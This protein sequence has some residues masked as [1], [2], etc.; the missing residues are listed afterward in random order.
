MKNNKITLFSTGMGHF[1]RYY[2]LR[3]G[4][5]KKIS[6]P[7][8]K[9]HIGDVATSINAFGKVKYAVPPSFAPNNVSETFLQ[10]DPKNSLNSLLTSLSGSEVSL[11]YQGNEAT[12]RLLG[13]SLTPGSD[14]E[15]VKQCMSVMDDQNNIKHL[16]LSYISSVKFTNEAVQAEINKALNNNFQKIK[17]EST[18]LDLTLENL[19]K[20]E[21][22]E[23]SITY[24]VPVAAWKM[25]YSIRQDK[26]KF[27][28]EG[29]VIVDNNTDEDWDNFIINVVTGNPMSFRTDIADI[30]LPNRRMVNLV[31]SYNYSNS[32]SK[33]FDGYTE[34]AISETTT[35]PRKALAVAASFSPKMNRSVSE[36][37][38][39][40][41]ACENFEDDYSNGA[42][43]VISDGV[44]TKEIGDFC[45]FTAKAPITIASKKSAIVTMFT[46]PLKNAGTVL[47]YEPQNHAR[48]PYRAIKFKNETTHTLGRGKVVIYNEGVFSGECILDTAKIGDNRMLP[49][50]LENGVK[51]IIED[52]NSSN[53]LT[54]INITNDVA[55][56]SHL[57]TYKTTYLLHN[58]KEKSFDIAIQYM[59]HY[60]G[61][62]ELSYDKEIIK[63]CEKTELGSRLYLKLEPNQKINLTICET[64]ISSQTVDIAGNF[65]WIRQNIIATN[66]DLVN[67]PTIQECIKLQTE[68]DF[69]QQEENDN[70][71]KIGK[72][73]ERSDR[74][75]QN[76]N[77]VSS[78][79]DNNQLTTWIKDLTDGETEIKKI[80]DDIIPAIKLKRKTTTK[81]LNE[82]IN[83][84][85]A[86]WSKN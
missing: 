6:I 33:S 3:A 40:M 30:K 63:S 18:F 44:D 20:E 43:P 29:A 31:D 23:A 61:Q 46:V 59:N 68:L 53:V 54:N 16:L 47:L 49:H 76:I 15:P 5:S 45:V 81:K 51:I 48:R 12:Y 67:N 27:F 9:E 60:Q 58:K 19:S 72:L 13:I 75:R 78:V 65:F 38:D 77:T 57:Q 50:C 82:A 7:F 24:T 71:H 8:K 73:I 10:I 35:I 28:L 69:L 32:L 21:E 62:V 56:Q 34:Y 86:S 26:N 17:P 64:N 80:Q 41:G 14:T 70:V 85:K 66:N 2:S 22:T 37:C 4:E 84:I 25:R 36:S 83:K 55:V 42:N 39:M 74:T 79:A 1:E 52:Q 11:T